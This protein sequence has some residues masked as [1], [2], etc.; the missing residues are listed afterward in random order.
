MELYDLCALLVSALFCKN[1]TVAYFSWPKLFFFLVASRTFIRWL[2]RIFTNKF[3]EDSFL[4]F[5][6]AVKSMHSYVYCLWVLQLGQQWRLLTISKSLYLS[7]V[8]FFFIPEWSPLWVSLYRLSEYKHDVSLCAVNC[9]TILL[10]KG[11]CVI[12]SIRQ[13]PVRNMLW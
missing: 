4:V 10:Y 9:A 3:Y 2:K 12:H 1:H 7:G 8:I 6:L 5:L 11:R 13:C